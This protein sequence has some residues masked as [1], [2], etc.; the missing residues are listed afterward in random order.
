MAVSATITHIHRDAVEFPEVSLR[1]SSVAGPPVSAMLG[2]EALTV[3]S[4]AECDL[5]LPDSSV[6]RLHASFQLTAGGVLLCDLGSKNGTFVSGVRVERGF[7]SPGVSVT[8]GRSTGEVLTS[9]RTAR[10]P[11]HPAPWFGKALGSS[12]AMRALF[13][14]LERAA[15]SDETVLLLGESGTGKELLARAIHERSPRAAARFVVLD[16]SALAPNLM[17]AEIFGHARG[18]FTGAIQ[19]RA[20]VFEDA[21]GGTLFIDEIGELPL[22]LQPKLLRALESGQVRRLGESQF[23]DVDVRIVAATHR[24]VRGRVASR[25]FREDLYYRLAVVEA[26]VPPLRERRED[27]AAL[28]EHFLREKSP[29]LTL[30]ALPSNTVALLSAHDWPGNVRELRNT[31]ARLVIFPEAP[32]DAIDARRADANSLM[33]HLLSLSL[34]D[35]R[36]VVVEDF[37]RRYLRAKLAACAGNVTRAAEGMGVTRQFLH[38][39]LERYGI[40]R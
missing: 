13:A 3:G 23:R 34:R 22:D 33:G 1:F 39:L 9:Q 19:A 28:T 18:A 36:A 4:G 26:K 17:E 29:G 27:I 15:G 35:A 37:E 14:R 7:V 24:D 11:I 21:H 6:S 38:R 31:V 40:E 32:E 2:V 8:I 16:C 25:E 12:F 10:V 5:V 20:G 30:D